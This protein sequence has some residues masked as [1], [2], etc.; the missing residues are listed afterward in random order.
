MVF[1]STLLAFMIGIMYYMLYPGDNKIKDVYIPTSE[2][3]VSG[4]LTQH[5]A[6]KQFA[7]DKIIGIVQLTKEAKSAGKTADKVTGGSGIPENSVII[8]SDTEEK[9]NLIGSYLAGNATETGNLHPGKEASVAIHEDT[10]TLLNQEF[11]SVLACMNKPERK[12]GDTDSYVKDAQLVDCKEATTKYVITYGAVPMNDLNTPYTRGRTL[13]WERAILKR[14]HGSPDCGFLYY[15]GGKV[16]GKNKY[17][18]HNSNRLTR[19]VPTDFTDKVLRGY[20]DPITEA[21]RASI[22]NQ[23]AD[24]LF[25]MTPINDPYPR[26]NLKVLLD[27]EFNSFSS[28]GS[29]YFNLIHD[30]NVGNNWI[31]LASPTDEKIMINAS[32]KNSDWFFSSCK[33]SNASNI[34]ACEEFENRQAFSFTT[35]RYFNITKGTNKEFLGSSFTISMMVGLNGNGTIFETQ[36]TAGTSGC[37]PTTSTIGTTTYQ[38]PCLVATYTSGVSDGQLEIVLK[39]ADGKEAKLSSG[40]IV[41]GIPT[42]IDYIFNSTGHR[43]YINGQHSDSSSYEGAIT[44]IDGLAGQAFTFG[45]TGNISNLYNLAVYNRGGM[46]DVTTVD[47]KFDMYGLPRIYKSNKTRYNKN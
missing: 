24:I 15:N 28:S 29:K 36:T 16:A 41:K 45:G 23:S 19:G 42:Q 18:I 17:F 25:C 46:S 32:G 26:T 40:L 7:R 35:D 34:K 31:N 22:G 43:L 4:F 44:N 10:S 38:Q 8:L 27:A 9:K 11:V 39:G 1:W 14:T 2:A 12:M 33:A 5:Q 37:T 47:G 30:D 6:A 20:I 21:G 3:F 13:L